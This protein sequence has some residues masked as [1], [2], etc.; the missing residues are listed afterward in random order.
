MWHINNVKMFVF[1]LHKFTNGGGVPDK[2]VLAAIGLQQEFWDTLSCCWAAVE[3]DRRRR[4][5]GFVS[6]TNGFRRNQDV[7]V[8]T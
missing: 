1:Y 7:E 5:F 2:Q 4:G 8:S 6:S 3:Q